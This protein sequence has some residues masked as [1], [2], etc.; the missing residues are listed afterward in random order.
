MHLADTAFREVERGADL[1]HRQFLVVVEDDDQP[2][3]AVEPLGDKP[4]E[5]RFLDPASR[6]FTLF[7]FEDVDL[8]NIFR[9][10]GLAPLLV[11]ADETHGVGVDQQ[12]LKLLVRKPHVRGDLG[13]GRRPAQLRLQCLDRL[14]EFAGLRPHQAGHPVHRPQFVEHRPADA[15]HAVGLELHAP[16]HVERID[17]VHQAERAR[18]YEI[19]EFDAVRQ[20]RPDAL[21]VV[22]DQRQKD[23]DEPVTKLLVRLVGLEGRPD[24]EHLLGRRLRRIVRHDILLERALHARSRSGVSAMPRPSFHHAGHAPSWCIPAHRTLFFTACTIDGPR[25][26]DRHRPADVASLTFFPLNV[27][28]GGPPAIPDCPI[29]WRFCVGASRRPQ[30]LAP[31]HAGKDLDAILVR[32]LFGSQHLHVRQVA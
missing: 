4:H 27:F 13:V 30:H 14:V 12:F 17:R 26:T 29:D 10:V 9:T 1:F 7:V 23:L 16:R 31:S 5:I 3:V 21:A 19:V 8:A 20:A 18:R 22:F 32:Q 6:I 2:L 11:E 24:F 25:P 28:F 15:R